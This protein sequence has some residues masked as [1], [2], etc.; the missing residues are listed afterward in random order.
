MSSLLTDEALDEVL[1]RLR[2]FALSLAP[3]PASADDLV[4]SCL[5]TALS[6]AGSR[7]P[8]GDLRAWLFSILYRRFLDGR[9]RASRYARILEFLGGADPLMAPS[10]EAVA[11]ARASLGDLGRLAADQQSVLLL[12]SV[13]GLGY[14]EAADVLGI[15]IG[16]VMSRLSRARKALRALNEGRI[17][18][19]PA[20]RILK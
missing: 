10:A 14:Q 11:M 12:V 8:D 2:R 5:E 6:R 16:T 20:L 1:P 13:E 15:P 3:D 19:Q 18:S 9:R 17:V 4:Q 7:R